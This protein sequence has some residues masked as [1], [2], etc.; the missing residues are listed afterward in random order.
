T[1]YLISCNYANSYVVQ[2]LIQCLNAIVTTHE[3]PVRQIPQQMLRVVDDDE[4]DEDTRGVAIHVAGLLDYPLG[5]SRIKRLLSRRSAKVIYSVCEY[6][7]YRVGILESEEIAKSLLA[8][9]NR[10]DS[11]CYFT[12][13]Q[14]DTGKDVEADVRYYAA[15]CLALS[16]L[17]PEIE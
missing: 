6:I 2:D 16:E 10:P 15:R 13:L 8:V 4:D 17:Q 11:I 7:E 12:A 3:L 9:M 1:D 5:E 14:R